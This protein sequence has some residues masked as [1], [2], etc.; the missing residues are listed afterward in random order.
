MLFFRHA[1]PKTVKSELKCVSLLASLI[2]EGAF[3]SFSE[4]AIDNRPQELNCLGQ[5]WHDIQNKVKGSKHV[6]GR[7]GANA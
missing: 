4:T 6:E 2:L 3:G 5:A 1:N 7:M